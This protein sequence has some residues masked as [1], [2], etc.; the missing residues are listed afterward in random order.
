MF[1]RKHMDQDDNTG[2]FLQNLWF[3]DYFYFNCNIL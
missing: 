1:K 3:S 2:W